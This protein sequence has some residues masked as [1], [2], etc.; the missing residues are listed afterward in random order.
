MRAK[1]LA[2]SGLCILL[3]LAACTKRAAVVA[4]PRVPASPPPAIVALAE[5]DRAFA[6]SAYD[7]ACRA[8]EDYLR[9]TP[10]KDQQDQALFRLGL[11]Y[12]LRKSNPNWQRAITP[13]KR[14]MNDYPGS[15][16]KPPVELILAL[17]SEIAQV[18]MDIKTRDDRIKQLTT[19]LDRLKRIDADRRK[20]P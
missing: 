12:A 11:A 5:A 7:D 1:R 16:F 6:Q 9:L 10:A 18:S 2:T 14:L 8:Y 13:W 4:P 20:T 3:M 15:P 19:E 17:Y